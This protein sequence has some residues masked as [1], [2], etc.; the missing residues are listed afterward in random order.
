MI[1]ASPSA[2]HGS[3]GVADSPRPG[4]SGA[5]TVKSPR[6]R[7]HVADP[8]HPRA[9]AAM[10]QHQRR[11]AAPAAPRHRAVAARRV[12]PL[13][14]G[15]DAVDKIYRRLADYRHVPIASPC[16]PR[17]AAG[18][19]RVIAGFAPP[20]YPRYDNAA[21]GRAAEGSRGG[22]APFPLPVNGGNMPELRISTEKVCAFIEAA[23][24]V[25]GKVASTAG[26]RTT[27]GDDSK[28]ET[29]VDEPG[30]DI[31]EGDDRRRQMVEF[32]A[33]L[34]V[35]EQTDLLGADLART[36]RLRHRRMGQRA[37]GG[38]GADRGA[39][40]GL[41]DRR[42]GAAGISR[43]RARSLRPDLRLSPA[44]GRAR[45]DRSQRA[46]MSSP[47]VGS[48]R[49]ASGPAISIASQPSPV[50]RYTVAAMR[51]LST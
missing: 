47:I 22:V 37:G 33:G 41:H 50:R 18:Q 38:R 49:R 31:Y 35:E 44:T 43:R 14:L 17:R 42:C 48:C 3:G 34:N 13:G 8:V 51:S 24:E 40:P 12:D 11:A 9:I 16:F 19:A 45:R 39:R 20:A 26:D 46:A 23:R 5:M 15:R 25:A 32:V 7:Q 1:A 30:Q 10:Q 4:R 36:R 2:V 27:T 6:Q 21:Q 28:L 29:I